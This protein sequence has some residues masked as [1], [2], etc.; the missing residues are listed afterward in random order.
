MDGSGY[1][2]DKKSF[3]GIERDDT[4]SDQHHAEDTAA[5]LKVISCLHNC[6]I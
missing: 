6:I 4:Y 1:H 2:Q 5:V 3:G